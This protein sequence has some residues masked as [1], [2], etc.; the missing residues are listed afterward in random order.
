[1]TAFIGLDINDEVAVIE[2][3]PYNI[4]CWGAGAG[5]K[6]SANRD[7]YAHIQFEVCE[8][9]APRSNLPPTPAQTKYYN[10]VWKLTED[11]CV[12]LCEKFGFTAKNITSHYEAHA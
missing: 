2:T 11:Y 9:N 4:A 8:D 3:L 1:M 12:Y 10:D 7:P 6:G 5:P